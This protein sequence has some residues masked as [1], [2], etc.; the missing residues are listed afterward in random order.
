MCTCLSFSLQ[1]RT[2][3]RSTYNSALSL[4]RAT[5]IRAACAIAPPP[6]FNVRRYEPPDIGKPGLMIT[7]P[8][9]EAKANADRVAAVRTLLKVPPPPVKAGGDKKGDKKG[10]DKKGGKKKK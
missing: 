2:T 10:G 8:D 1:R 4:K 6:T 5:R 7:P 3:R 9:A